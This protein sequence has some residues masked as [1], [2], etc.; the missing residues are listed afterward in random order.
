MYFQPGHCEL[1]YALPRG[2]VGTRIKSSSFN[3]LICYF[4]GITKQLGML[5]ITLCVTTQERGNE[6]T[7]EM[8]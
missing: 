7:K 5:R 4:S 8:A 6:I 2:S 1:P 3:H